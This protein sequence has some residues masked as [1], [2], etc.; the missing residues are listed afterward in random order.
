M[1]KLIQNFILLATCLLMG[2]SASAFSVNVDDAWYD[3]DSDNT[4]ELT[5]WNSYETEI[6]VPECIEYEGKTYQVTSIGSGAFHDAPR[7]AT[8]NI[9][10]SITAIG[11]NAFGYNNAFSYNEYLKDIN[12]IDENPS[13]SSV[14]GLL[15]S[16][17]KTT[18]VACGRGRVG[19]ISIHPQ[20]ENISEYAFYK[21][22][23]LANIALPNSVTYI[24]EDAF[25]GCSSLTSI[26][27][28]NSLTVI[29]KSVFEDC[30]SLTSITIPSS[31]TTIEESA[32]SGCS[33]LTSVTLSNSVTAISD[34]CFSHCRSLASITIP[35]SVTSIGD[36]AFY[37][38]SSLKTVTIGKNVV[39]IGGSA[40]RWCDHLTEIYCLPTIPPVYSASWNFRAV[41]YVP[42]GS[43]EDYKGNAVWGRFKD[44]Q[45]MDFSGIEGIVTDGSSNH[46]SVPVNE[47]AMEVYNLNGARLSSSLHGLPSGI[48]LVRQGSKTVKVVL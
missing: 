17:D 9:P 36:Y 37:E 45:E 23:K 6:T 34:H 35:N 20:V 43:K 8:V 13:Y 14:D 42:F 15:Y 47:E 10:A 27:I 3:V 24:G 18:L 29:R 25:N 46:K 48:Y 7:M 11:I 19:D 31:V 40:F 26:A 4:A 30:L 28:P 21:C 39:V 22:S 1:K 32:F 12:I 16:K 38:C 44:I 5:S 33:S 2:M 41:L